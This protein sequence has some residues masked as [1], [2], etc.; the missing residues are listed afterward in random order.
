[1]KKRYNVP[2]TEEQMLHVLTGLDAKMKDYQKS[3]RASKEAGTDGSS[4]QKS[5]DTIGKL[6]D[7]VEGHWYRAHEKWHP[8]PGDQLSNGATVIAFTPGKGDGSNS[9]VLAHRPT[10]PVHKWVTWRCD[11]DGSHTV[12]GH[13]M[14][15]LTEA[16]ADYK[17]RG[18]DA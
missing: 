3:F 10:H 14:A 6:A 16:V 7:K 18:G 5:I 12:A 8:E 9:V 4:W 11:K 2:L 17:D 15:T 1:M 13:Y